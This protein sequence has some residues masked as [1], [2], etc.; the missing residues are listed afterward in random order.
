MGDEN[1][2]S[3]ISVRFTA[4]RLSYGISNGNRQLEA[5]MARVT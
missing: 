2:S 3:D 4:H 5:T 1:D